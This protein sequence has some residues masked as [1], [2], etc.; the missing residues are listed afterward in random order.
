MVPPEQ[1]GRRVRPRQRNKQEDVPV[2]PVEYELPMDPYKVELRAYQD[3]IG[4]SL[5][6]HHM[7]LAHMMHHMRIPRMDGAPDYPLY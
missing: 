1:P 3:D 7:N 2:I 6:Y 4:H 5:N